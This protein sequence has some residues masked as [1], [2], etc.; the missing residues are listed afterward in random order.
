MPDGDI[1][2]RKLAGAGKGWVKI[3][4]LLYME[5]ERTDLGSELLKAVRCNLD[6]LP[7]SYVQEALGCLGTALRI[8]MRSQDNST[9]PVDGF[10]R[11]DSSL[12]ALDDGGAFSTSQIV[13]DSIR[14]VFNTNRARAHGLSTDEIISKF[15]LT[16]QNKF[17]VSRFSRIRAELQNAHGRT[18]QDQAEWERGVKRQPGDDMVKMI[19]RYLAGG[20]IKFRVPARRRPPAPSLAELLSR[21]IRVGER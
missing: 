4:R 14:S 20:G 10:L 21:P 18:D 16:F 1:F 7:P 3:F 5:P 8:E 2:Q 13:G 17:L 9:V 12:R 11:L 15:S 19:Q 6:Q